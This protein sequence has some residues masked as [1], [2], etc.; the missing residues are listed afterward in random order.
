MLSLKRPGKE[1]NNKKEKQTYTLQEKIDGKLK[2]QEGAA[3]ELTVWLHERPEVKATVTGDLVQ[4]AKNQPLAADR[5]EKQMRKT[6]NTPFAFQN[7]DMELVGNLFLPMQ[8]LNEIRRAALAELEQE[9]T[10]A[11]RRRVK[12]SDAI[13]KEMNDSS[14]AE[15]GEVQVSVNTSEQLKVVLKKEY[16][17]RIFVSDEIAFDEKTLK[18]VGEYRRK[19][20]EQNQNAHVCLAMPYIFRERAMQLY[21]K[22]YNRLCEFYDGVLVRNWEGLEWL[23]ARKY[24]GEICSDYN[25]YGWNNLA[26]KELSGIGIDR[27][28][29][30][31]ELNYRE[32]GEVGSSG[33]LIVYGYQP[34]MI[35]ANCI[36]RT[37]EGCQGKDGL[38][39]ITD[40]LGNKFPV[41]NYCKYC[42]NVMY[43]SSPL[44]LLDQKKE[45][46]SLNPSG[47]RLNFTL[48]NT[49]EMEQILENYNHVFLKDKEIPMPDKDF[50]RGHFKRGVK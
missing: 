26:V 47:I 30:S 31:V 41:K 19:L 8:T 36:R 40:R 7:L 12:S 44:V 28:T 24:S 45:I 22:Y 15:T 37:T 33:D 20:K 49:R 46:R 29:S 34:V 42:Y 2:L 4:T 5:I 25:L 13:A 17:N 39:F 43:N 21:E 23:K 11:Y 9:I 38:L 6:G 50:T 10:G 18:I 1:I 3:S 32:L 27:Y 16:V 14:L 35:T 48:E